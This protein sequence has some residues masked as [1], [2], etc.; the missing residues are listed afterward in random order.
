[1]KKTTQ[2]GKTFLF[3]TLLVSRAYQTNTPAVPCRFPLAG[4]ADILCTNLFAEWLF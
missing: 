4:G 2:L 1:M 3:L